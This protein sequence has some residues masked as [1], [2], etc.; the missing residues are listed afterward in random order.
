[1]SSSRRS[2]FRTTW[3]VGKGTILLIRAFRWPERGLRPRGRFNTRYG[4][5]LALRDR[6]GSPP[7]LSSGGSTPPR[8]GPPGRTGRTTTVAATGLR[9]V[10]TC[11]PRRRRDLTGRQ[12]W[13]REKGEEPPWAGRSGISTRRG[14]ARLDLAESATGGRQIGWRS[15]WSETATERGWWT[16]ARAAQGAGRRCRRTAVSGLADERSGRGSRD[17]AKGGDR[18]RRLEGG[19]RR[20][21]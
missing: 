17:Q 18:R 6:G 7:G 1:V 5:L 2:S 10:L 11:W 20:R 12:Q 16:P 15:R 14:S 4:P 21:L 13:G 19:S 9:A 3:K 8:R